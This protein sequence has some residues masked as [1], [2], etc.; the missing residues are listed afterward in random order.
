VLKD[1]GR[2]K[3]IPTEHLYRI[4]N[5]QVARPPS[6]C[7]RSSLPKA[8]LRF[9]SQNV[10]P[11]T[12]EVPGGSRLGWG[13][14]RIPSLLP[15]SSQRWLRSRAGRAP[16]TRPDCCLAHT[17]AL[18]VSCRGRQKVARL[19]EEEEEVSLPEGVCRAEGLC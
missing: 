5:Q 14:R 17:R 6:L 13:R 11:G 8:T 10:I 16:C 1:T 18:L 3:A 19:E 12:Q 9:L 7:F 2:E 15:T 4:R